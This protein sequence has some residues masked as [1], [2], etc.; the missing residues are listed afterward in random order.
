MVG[1]PETLEP[2]VIAQRSLEDV[3]RAI[4][5]RRLPPVEGWDPDHCGDSEMR[6]SR[7]GSW[8]HQG[9]PIFRQALI[10][11]FSRILRREADGSFVLV[12]PAE[13]LSIEVEL[14]PFVATAMIS[15]GQGRER[16]LAFAINSGDAVL[17]GPGHA[18]R[19]EYGMP[20][21]HVRSG[22]DAMLARPVYYE[23]AE[24]ALADSPE[25]PGVWSGGLFFP[26]DA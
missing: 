12:T 22:L 6:I 10:R 23:L 1:M 17:L 19:I 21:V 2:I 9:A 26:L 5:E 14:A 16:Q 3:A 15:E 13:K 20:L 11:Q 24:I 4:G 7:D 8:T 25:E 18:L